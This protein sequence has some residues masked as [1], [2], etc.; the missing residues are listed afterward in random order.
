MQVNLNVFKPA[1]AV[2]FTG[3]NHKKSENGTQE[4]EFNFPHDSNK[5]DCYLEVFSVKKDKNDNYNVNKMLTNTDLGVQSVKL[6]NGGVKIDMGYAYDEL[7]NKEPFAYRYKLVD[8]KDNSKSFYQVD[9]GS[10]L[11]YSKNGNF[12]KFNLVMQDGTQVAKGG[13]MTLALPDSYAVGWVYDE[14][15][16]PTLNKDIQA[17]AKHATKTF[18]NKLGGGLAGFEANID[19]LKK[20]GY[21]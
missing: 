8:K 18:S 3:F 11:D 5:Y 13:S 7:A 6:G 10:V 19:K 16:K 14:K 1:K 15:G 12:D 2:N 20:A 9:A 17:K 21:P 4:F